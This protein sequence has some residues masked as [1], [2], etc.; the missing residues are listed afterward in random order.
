MSDDIHTL[1]SDYLSEIQQI[2]QTNLSL[3]NKYICLKQILER[4]CKEITKGESLQFPSLFSRLVFISQKYDLPKRIEWRL[5]TIRIKS[6]FLQRD[7]DNLVTPK[8]YADAKQ[9]IELFYAF[10]QG[11]HSLEIP[12]GAEQ[13]DKKTLPLDRL[14]VQV[15]DIDKENELLICQ[16]ETLPQETL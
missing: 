4:S 14:R 1:I 6:S 15:L 12:E 8:Q 7:E 11:D 3:R 16:P 10:L 9:S 13:E 2:D 5:H